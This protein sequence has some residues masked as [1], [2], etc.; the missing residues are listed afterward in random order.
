MDDIFDQGASLCTQ[1][2]CRHGL[3]DTFRHII[4]YH[5]IENNRLFAPEIRL[6]L[7]KETLSPSMQAVPDNV[8]RRS[9]PSCFHY[10]SLFVLCLLFYILSMNC[11]C[12]RTRL[13]FFKNT[14]L[15]F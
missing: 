13:T 12:A 14:L 8:A 6:K 2:F 3:E 5:T 10:L 1:T 7:T 9:L 4:R 15:F 11:A